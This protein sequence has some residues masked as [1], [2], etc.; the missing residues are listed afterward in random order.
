MAE[1]KKE[2]EYAKLQKIAMPGFEDC[3]FK[4]SIVERFT[5]WAW[6]I[7]KQ[8]LHRIMDKTNEVYPGFFDNTSQ[9]RTYII[10]TILKVFR[11]DENE[12]LLKFIQQLIP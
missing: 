8:P 10:S 1:L 11:D 5:F 4:Y 3:D 9:T 7:D 2:L 6:F 12:L